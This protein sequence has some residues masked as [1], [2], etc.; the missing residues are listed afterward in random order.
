MPL[1]SSSSLKVSSRNKYEFFVLTQWNGCDLHETVE[2]DIA[3]DVGEIL[4]PRAV[5]VGEEGHRA[6]LLHAHQLG[7]E[8]D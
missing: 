8:A 3:V 1:Q 6:H 4:P 5:H 7:L 2:V